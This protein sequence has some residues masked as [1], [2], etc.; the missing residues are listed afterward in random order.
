M[1][2]IKSHGKLFFDKIVGAWWLTGRP[3]QRA[4]ACEIVSYTEN[5]PAHIPAEDRNSDRGQ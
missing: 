3:V 2:E 1:P 4:A 5:N